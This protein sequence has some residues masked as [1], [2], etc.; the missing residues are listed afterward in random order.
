MVYVGYPDVP[1]LGRRRQGAKQPQISAAFNR[2]MG[3][4]VGS[5]IKHSRE[6]LDDRLS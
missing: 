5:A 3:N 1:D 6:D 2:Q 4:S